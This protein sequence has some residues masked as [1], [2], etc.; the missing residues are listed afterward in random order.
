MALRHSRMVLNRCC[1]SSSV[2]SKEQWAY[3]R[4]YSSVMGGKA[5]KVDKNELKEGKKKV[6]GKTKK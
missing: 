2:K 1:S 4:V 5:S 3:A 6:K